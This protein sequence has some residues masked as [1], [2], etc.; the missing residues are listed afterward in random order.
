[1]RGVVFLPT[2]TREKSGL[3]ILDRNQNAQSSDLYRVQHVL[4]NI[5]SVTAGNI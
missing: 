4:V 2:R 5:V 3:G 1:M